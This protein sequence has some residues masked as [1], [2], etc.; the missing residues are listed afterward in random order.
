MEYEQESWI[1]RSAKGTHYTGALTTDQMDL[2][3]IGVVKVPMVE[4]RRLTLWSDQ[5]LAWDVMFFKSSAGQP[6][7]DADLDS[8]VDW[9][10]FEAADGVQV[11]GTGLWRYS[12]TG[13]ELRY[14]PSDSRFNV[15]L[16][17]RDVTSKISGATGEVVIELE[18]PV[19]D[20]IAAWRLT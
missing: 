16:I 13:M 2:E 7:A 11:A 19:F 6:S 15:G 20:R 12:I 1:V 4:I 8:M 5:N 10:S 3:D 14:R 18:G 9:I 17:N